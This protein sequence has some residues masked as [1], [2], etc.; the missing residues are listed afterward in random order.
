MKEIGL[1]VSFE[2]AQ[3]GN[4]VLH[5]QKVT[6]PRNYVSNTDIRF[7]RVLGIYGECAGIDFMEERDLTYAALKG[8]KPKKVEIYSLFA[9]F[10]DE[11]MFSRVRAH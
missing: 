3:F 11:T 5:M 1:K 2:P 8:R 7:R 9:S 6:N 4:L 10:Q